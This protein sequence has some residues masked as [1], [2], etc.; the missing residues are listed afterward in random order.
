MR[1]GVTEVQ[2]VRGQEVSGQEIQKPGVQV[3]R[4]RKQELERCGRPE[5][6]R[7]RDLKATRSR[8]ILCSMHIKHETAKKRLRRNKEK[9][10]H[11]RFKEIFLYE[12]NL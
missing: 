1:F 11:W 12:Y 6:R 2:E 5:V 4:S 10:L 8:W 9:I 7:S 3:S